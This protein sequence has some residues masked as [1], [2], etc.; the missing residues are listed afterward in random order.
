MRGGH[1]TG[2]AKVRYRVPVARTERGKGNRMSTVTE[3]IR[4]HLLASLGAWPGPVRRMPSLEELR[5]RQWSPRFEWLRSNRMVLGAFRYGLLE[6]QRQ[7]SPY[8]NVGSLIARA[9]AY[10]DT[11]NTECLVDVANLAMVEF[12]IGRHP[13]K[14]FRAVDDGIHTARK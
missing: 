14:H 4:N 6:R 13:A 12:E 11:G 1:K 5:D 8:D 9:K 3:H 7:G 10:Q 2:W